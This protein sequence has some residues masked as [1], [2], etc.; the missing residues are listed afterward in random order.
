MADYEFGDDVV[1]PGG[2]NRQISV[3]NLR[4]DDEDDAAVTTALHRLLVCTVG[5]PLWAFGSELEPTLY[6]R[7]VSRTVF[8]AF[9]GSF[10]SIEQICPPVSHC[11]TQ[12]F[13]T[14][15]LRTAL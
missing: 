10:S 1:F 8:E 3:R 13:C 9:C 7:K 5:R 14:S 12:E 4:G 11:G 15:D 6:F 2:D